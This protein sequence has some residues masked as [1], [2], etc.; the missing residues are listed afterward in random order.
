VAEAVVT[1]LVVEDGQ[2]CVELIS[3]GRSHRNAEPRNTR[4]SETEHATRALHLAT[5]VGELSPAPDGSGGGHG[6]WP[7]DVQPT[8]DRAQ[9]GAPL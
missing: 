8:R 6:E 9:R 3:Q 1:I 7:E 4:T 2:R 5:Q